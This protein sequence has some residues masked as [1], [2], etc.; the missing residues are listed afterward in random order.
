MNIRGDIPHAKIENINIP[1]NRRNLIITGRNGSGKTSFLTTLERNILNNLEKKDQQLLQ[2]Q[3]NIES[4]INYRNTLAKTSEQYISISNQIEREQ[5]KIQLLNNG[6]QLDF[7]SFDELQSNYDS[8]KAIFRSF[9]AMRISSIDHATQTTSLIEE[10]TIAK[11]NFKHNLGS[12]LEQHLINVKTSEA[13]AKGIEKDE[14]KGKK[15]EEWFNLF[16]TSL[17]KLFENNNAKLVFSNEERKF[18]ITDGKLISSFQDLSS[19]YKA[20]FDIYADLLLRTEFFD[21]TPSELQGIVLIDE[22]DAHLHISLQK[23]ILP[24]FSESFPNIQFIVSTHS[25]FVITSTDN[26]T[27]VYDI[28]S[29]EFFEDDL[30]YYSHESIIKEL[31]HVKEEN[32]NLKKLSGQLL[33]FIELKDSPKDLNTIQDLLN[34]IHKNFEKLSVELQLQYMV[35][36]NKLAKLK[37]EGN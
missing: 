34:E 10:K 16:D 30:S 24:F 20:I 37:H 12:K 17:K 28:S 32:E 21:I 27:V 18:R 1:L 25:P 6:F 9:P 11:Q 31:F 22:I 14:I 7:N 3:R 15:F 23:L 4:W 33:E 36:K 35:A 29:G 2:S 13:F 8:F 19:G 26:D 5:E